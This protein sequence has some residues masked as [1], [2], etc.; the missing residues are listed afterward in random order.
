M[1]FLFLS[2]DSSRQINQMTWQSRPTD[3]ADGLRYSL[4]QADRRFCFARRR[5]SMYRHG[6][7]FQWPPRLQRLVFLNRRSKERALLRPFAGR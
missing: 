7:A 4:K 1:G 2:P 5:M 3:A 6:H